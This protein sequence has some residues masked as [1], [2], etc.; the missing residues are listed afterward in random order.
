[1]GVEKKGCGCGGGKG[2][3]F[4]VCVCDMIPFATAVMVVI[5]AIRFDYGS[6]ELKRSSGG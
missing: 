2:G 1:M 5:I 4:G 3:V 6:S